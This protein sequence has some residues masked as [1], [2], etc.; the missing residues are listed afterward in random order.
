[1]NRF[2]IRILSTLCVIV[3]GGLASVQAQQDTLVT[4]STALSAYLNNGD[5]SYRW[6][7]VSMKPAPGVVRYDLLLTSQTWQ[8]IPWKHQLTL[9]IPERLSHSQVL[10][11]I[12]GGSLQRGEPRWSE[13]DKTQEALARLARQSEAPTA[14]IR[15]VPNQPLFDSLTE[16]ALIAYTLLHLQQTGD[17]SW[18]LL[19][20][21]TK[22]VVRAMDAITEFSA[23]QLQRKVE[24]FVVS[25]L[26]KRGWTT[27]LTAL[28][29]E[30]VIG[31]VP[32]VIDMLN[33][34]HSIPYQVEVM[35]TYSDQIADY[36]TSG[37]TEM[38]ATKEGEAIVQMIDPYSYRRHATMPKLLVMGT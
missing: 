5:L 14:Q 17:M 19:F 20:P 21:M 13:G 3:W 8:Q 25:G 7:V 4:P 11:M 26:S 1:M 18:P 35:G 29:D 32:M 33:M 6:E 31:A 27:W 22:S 23:E 2:W 36:S 30:R 10:L 37:I 28:S 34:P 15:Q 24:G 38:F 9:W 12:A 16:D